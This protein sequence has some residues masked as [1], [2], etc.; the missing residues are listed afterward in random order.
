METARS[1][2]ARLTSYFWVK[3]LGTP[4][5]MTGFFIA[6]FAIL[7]HPSTLP[8]E[9]PLTALDRWIPFHP[10]ALIP[11]ASLWL[12]VSLPSALMMRFR[13]LLDHTLGAAALGMTGLVIF[14]IW[15]TKTPP[16][17]IDWAAHP[18]MQFLKSMD[19]SGNACPS[20]HVAF[21]VF[22]ACWLA[23]MLKQIGA[24][25][26]AHV[27]NVLW[28]VVIIYSTLATRQ[29]VA[30]DALAGAVLGG[31][32]AFVNLKLCPEPSGPGHVRTGSAS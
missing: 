30:I 12:Y 4:L 6:Y 11:Y 26:C 13:E 29:H 20:L 8:W 19:A 27:I 22:G 23:R 15:P 14:S 21:A 7:R 16:A 1:I 31:M 17:N 10:A 5:F 28:A 25:S 2:A 24:G 3:A 32:I 18:H 9:V